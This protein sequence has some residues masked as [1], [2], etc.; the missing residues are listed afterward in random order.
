MVL[1]E[2]EKKQRAIESKKKYVEN[3]REKVRNQK[4]K[5]KKTEKG[6]KITKKSAWKKEGLNMDNF[7]EIYKLYLETTNCDICD[8]ILT[9]DKIRTSTTKCMDH[10]HQTG[11]FR[12]ILCQACNVRRK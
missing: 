3:N 4:K 1:T 11:E 7:E 10:C 6:K 12:N 2:E 5:Y 8:R 9:I